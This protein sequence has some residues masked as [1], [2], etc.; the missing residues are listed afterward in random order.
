MFCTKCGFNNA[1]NATICERCG[2]PIGGPAPKKDS[3]AIGIVLMIVFIALGAVS[4]V[5]GIIRTF[6]ALA[7][8]V[9]LLG[10]ISYV[11]PFYLITGIITDILVLVCAILLIAV[12]AVLIISALGHNKKNSAPLFVGTTALSL[13]VLILHLLLLITH[14]Y[15]WRYYLPVILLAIIIPAAAYILYILADERPY[16]EISADYLKMA[17][18][19]FFNAISEIINKLTKKN[20]TASDYEYGG[21]SAGPQSY[22][23][24]G[25]QSYQGN[26]QN[27]Q[28][29]PGMPGYQASKVPPM[30]PYRQ[31]VYSNVRVKEDRSILLY[32]ILTA[33]TCGI[34][35]LYFVHKMAQDLNVVCNGD[36]QE[37]TAGLGAL[38]GYSILTCGIYG[39]CYWYG[40][41]NRINLN[42]PR[43]G[44]ASEIDGL[45][46]L[47]WCTIGSLLCGIG[48]IIG[49]YKLI[50]SCNALCHAYNMQLNGGRY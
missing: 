7:A 49:L 37:A 11:N 15:A 8:V 17:V 18:G 30:P 26:A 3:G 28:A 31:T 16:I 2:A 10:Y 29:G 1:E 40:L 13:I 5:L 39:T 50:K 12:A 36:G 35:G 41:A 32:I 33:V 6:R 42:C 47:L 27:S 20:T 4:A 22:Q 9:S 38:I 45:H 44:V 48:P 25:A 46:Y 24:G 19:D 34:Y 43:Y 14:T 21:P 23:A